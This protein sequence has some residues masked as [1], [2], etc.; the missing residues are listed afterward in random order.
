MKKLQEYFIGVGYKRLSQVEVSAKASNQHE[1]NGVTSFKEL[2][3]KDKRNFKS[4]FI[5][6]SD[7]EEQNQEEFGY[8]TW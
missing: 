5:Y 7:D 3:G 4:R 1:L 6:L 8:C 2:F